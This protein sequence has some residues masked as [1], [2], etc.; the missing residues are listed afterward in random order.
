MVG[1]VE[2]AG[3]ST[4]RKNR[5]DRPF[6]PGET[7]AI[8]DR[9]TYPQHVQRVL[10]HIQQHLD[11]ELSRTYE[12]I[13]AGWLP[14]SGREPLG[15]CMEIYLND[16]NTTPPAD[17]RTEIW[18]PLAEERGQRLETASGSGKS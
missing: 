15:P 16:P 4:N 8:T 13:Y 11:E 1:N 6:L 9:E 3:N 14:E 18:I 7:G 2:I 12:R 17:L 10:V 5:Q